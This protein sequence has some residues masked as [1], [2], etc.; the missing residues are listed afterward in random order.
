ML[1]STLTHEGSSRDDMA[2]GLSRNQHERP[3]P[4]LEVYLQNPAGTG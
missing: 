3:G 4:S 2:N 1:L